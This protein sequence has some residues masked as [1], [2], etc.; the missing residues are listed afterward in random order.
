MSDHHEFGMSK[1]PAVL[2]CLCFKGREG[3]KDAAFGTEKHE[4][5]AHFVESTKVGFEADIPDDL[6]ARGAYEGAKALVAT[7]EALGGNKGDIRTETR[8]EIKE[9]ALEGVYGTADAVWTDGE[10]ILV[11]DFK[12]FWNPSRK[13]DAQLA[14]YAWAVMTAEAPEATDV[15]LMVC[16]GDNPSKSYVQ[17]LNVMSLKEIVDTVAEARIDRLAATDNDATQC[18]WCELC[19]RNTTCP[20]LRKVAEAVTKPIY[21][22]I[23]AQWETLPVEVKAQMLV[24]AETVSK[25]A[26]AVREKAKEDLLNGEAIEDE[27]NGIRYVLQHR[28]GRKTPRPVDAWTMLVGRGVDGEAIKARLSIKATDVK[29]LL[30]SVGIKGKVADELVESV[31]DVGNGSTVMVRG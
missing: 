16:Y 1:W 15:V 14:G 22:S 21:A 8:V 2:D 30:K 9:G 18:G 11:C 17:R 29:D 28:S 4:L 13:Y 12:T 6:H 10:T 19:E 27:A 3:G 23:P 5:F 25:W 24:L 26:D 31:S 20:S 7:V